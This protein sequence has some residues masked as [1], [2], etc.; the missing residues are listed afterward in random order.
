[1]TADENLCSL[2]AARLVVGWVGTLTKEDDMMQEAALVFLGLVIV[3]VVNFLGMR[4]IYKAI[5]E[6]KK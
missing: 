1:L 3:A 4:Q 5:Q 2:F 6:G